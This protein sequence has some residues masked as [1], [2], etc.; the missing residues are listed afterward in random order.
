MVP[1]GRQVRPGGI[2]VASFFDG[3]IIKAGMTGGMST[4][5]LSLEHYIKSKCVGYVWIGQLNGDARAAE[6]LLLQRMREVY[7]PAQ[8]N[9]WFW[10][11]SPEHAMRACREIAADFGTIEHHFF[12]PECTFGTMEVVL[13]DTF[14]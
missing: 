9:E 7:K 3:A 6:K 13:E 2:Y 12:K 5:V 10:C 4:R 8:G 14:S 1:W 11:E